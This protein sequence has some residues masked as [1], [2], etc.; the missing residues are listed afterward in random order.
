MKIFLPL[1]IR[2]YTGEENDYK[3]FALKHAKELFNIGGDGHQ[4]PTRM[5]QDKSE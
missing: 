5:N 3:G 1:L 4:Q 2:L